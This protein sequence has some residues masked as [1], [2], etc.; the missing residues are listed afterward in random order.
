MYCGEYN[1]RL[2]LLSAYWLSYVDHRCLLAS[3]TFDI[4]FAR[5]P[6]RQDCKKAQHVLDS[7]EVWHVKKWERKNTFESQMYF[8]VGT[9]LQK[10]W[11]VEM[12]L[13]QWGKR[14]QIRMR[15]M[16]GWDLLVCMRWWTLNNK[17]TKNILGWICLAEWNN[18][19]FLCY[20]PPNSSEIW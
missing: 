19:T 18:N 6:I 2:L 4:R 15:R 14:E 1:L 5:I 9:Q 20:P 8:L 16:P 17:K 3:A 11:I 7:W 12:T 10:I 13:C